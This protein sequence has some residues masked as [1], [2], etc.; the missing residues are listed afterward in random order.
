MDSSTLNVE[1]VHKSYFQ[2]NKKIQVLTGI[3]ATFEQ[4]KTYSNGF[5]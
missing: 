4:N 5:E 1:N 3:D 2:G